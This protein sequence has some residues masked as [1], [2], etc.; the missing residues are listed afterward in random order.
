[1]E[2]PETD[3][4]R[5]PLWLALRVLDEPAAVF[6]QLAARPRAL[7]P[8]IFL[9]LAAAVMAF[10][11][12]AET[13]RATARDQADAMERFMGD[14]FTEADRI[15][16][17]DEAANPRARGIT[18]AAVIVGGLISMSVTALVLKL[19]FGATSGT[20]ITFRD[21]FAITT[22]AYV[23]QMVGMVLGVALMAFA[24]LER[25]EFSLGFLFS[26]SGSFWQVFAS[27]I[28]FFGVWGVLLLAV[29]NQIKTKVPTLTGTL[30]VVGGLW[31][32]LKLIGAGIGTMFLP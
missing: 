21:E 16:V 19:I 25:P 5:D 11:T 10:G 29:G 15:R 30:T 23:P 28:T 8:V 2:S 9:A 24:G 18:L 6:R 17:I 3:A 22:H 27:Q 14:Q 20:E 4:P 7:V 13:L 32:L 12:P 1:M 31:V 26:D